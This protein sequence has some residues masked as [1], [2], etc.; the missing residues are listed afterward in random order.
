M[1]ILSL[2]YAPNQVF[3][4]KASI[5][6]KVDDKVRKIVDDMFETL[7][8]EKAVGMGANMVGILKRI[9]I[10]DMYED[11]KPNPYTLINPK[12]IKSSKEKQVFEE[13]SICFPGISAKISRSEKITVEYLDYYGKPQTLEAEGFFATVIQHEIDY[14]DGKIYLDY[15]SKVKRDILLKKM[16]NYIK[17]NPPKNN[18]EC[19]SH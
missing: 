3:K 7:Y 1:A 10:V 5:V 9:A 4:Q 2:K 12:I 13:A 18:C 19:C 6:E 11:N 14:L 17:D 16:N 8:A 15:L